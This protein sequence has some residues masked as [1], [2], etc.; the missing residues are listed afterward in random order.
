MFNDA[1]T[2][3]FSCDA[4]VSV[5]PNIYGSELFGD[6]SFVCTLRALLYDRVPQDEPV[7]LK[8]VSKND[9][10]STISEMG[11]ESMLDHYISYVSSPGTIMLMNFCGT[12]A[13]NKEAFRVID[14]MSERYPD[15][16]ECKDLHLFTS[17]IGN[18]RFFINEKHKHTLVFVAA[19]DFQMW[20][21]IQ[22]FISR[23]VPWYFKDKPLSDEEKTL[24]A[25]LIEKDPANYINI[26]ERI[27][28]RFDFRSA[29]IKGLLSEFETAARRGQLSAV[30]N[31][32]ES[33]RYQLDE[34][35]SAY[36]RLIQA[37]E[38][39]KI[40]IAGLEHLIAE[41]GKESEIMDYFMC[42]KGLDPINTCDSQ[43]EFIVSCYLENF[44]PD[45]YE[46]I[47]DNP[48][49]YIYTATSRNALFTQPD[50]RK[51]F[52]D[53]IFS[54][55]P[56]L[57]IKMCAYYKIDLTGYVYSESHYDYPFEYVNQI[58]NPHLDQHDCLG[59]HRRYIEQKLMDGDC[60]YAIEQCVASAKSVNIG[61]SATF[62]G[63]L[64]KLFST[65]IGRVIELPDGS[66]V[67]PTAAFEWLVQ[68][69][70]EETNVQTN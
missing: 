7:C 59:N 36:R 31:S 17:R 30:K 52:L 70:K 49:S 22:S 58:P 1:V 48:N 46:R 38:D 50:N 18:A 25:S 51:K 24:A 28:E 11:W 41:G 16:T 53:A 21:Y 29:K 23:L 40:R 65:S 67:T 47:A 33:N 10:A 8:L 56:T 66:S 45:M 14:H 6:T 32:L 12:I 34:N 5:F 68:Q 55:E 60:I 27:A 2:T 62:P 63:F 3:K 13:A 20:H 44:D 4:A 35:E 54:E 9:R 43:L 39:L 69:E 26:M 19:L 42:N 37:R 57:K 15:Y 61:E 64:S